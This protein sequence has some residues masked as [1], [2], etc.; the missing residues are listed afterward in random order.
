MI[1]EFKGREPRI[2][3]VS[4][5]AVASSGSRIRIESAPVTQTSKS[6]VELIGLARG[7][8]PANWLLGADT[9]RP[10]QEVR[11]GS[12]RTKSLPCLL[13]D[14]VGAEFPLTIFINKLEIHC[15]ASFIKIYQ[16]GWQGDALAV[17]LI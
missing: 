10:G 11:I 1:P 3:S 7:V 16:I 9:I 6:G 17:L 15:H 8:I 13:F 4:D 2:D 14:F 5:D 12:G